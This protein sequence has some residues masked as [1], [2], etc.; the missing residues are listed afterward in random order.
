MLNLKL[1]FHIRLDKFLYYS[2]LDK[3]YN[4][5]KLFKHL[6]K[7]EDGRLKIICIEL[8]KFGNDLHVVD[9]RRT[10]ETNDKNYLQSAPLEETSF[11]EIHHYRTIN[12]GLCIII[13]QTYFRKEV[14]LLI[15]FKDENIFYNIL[16]G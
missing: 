16:Y 14:L 1:A 2:V 13:N 12:S 8:E 6:K 4:M 5:K 10:P 9:N 7:F 3:V 11:T 15:L